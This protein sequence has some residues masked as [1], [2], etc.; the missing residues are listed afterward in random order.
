MTVIAA[1][2]GAAITAD[3]VIL[4]ANIS[5]VRDGLALSQGTASFVASLTTL[6]LAAAVLGA[7]VLGDLY[8]MKRMFVV[9]L[10]GTVAAGLMS[11]LAP[12]VAILMVARALTGVAFAFLLG[13]S[14]A[15]V[16]AV[17]PARR[18]MAAI[19]LFL[20]AGYVVT[21]PMAAIG[22]LLVSHYGWRACFLVAPAVAAVTLVITLRFV[23]ETARAPGRLDLPAVV[24]LGAALLGVIYGISR[25]ENG[26]APA[27]VAPI[28]LGLIAAAGFV[29]RELH[30]RDPALDLRIFSS[31]R[32]NA[33]VTAGLATNF[34]TGGTMILLGFYLIAVRRESPELLGW[35][36]IPAT[37]LQA[38]AAVVAGRAAARCGER[39]VLI[40]GLGLMLLGLLSL[41]LLTETSALTVLFVPVAIIAAAGAVVQTPQATI[42]MSSAPAD[43]GGAVSAV[44]AGIGMAGY[45]LGPTVFLLVGTSLFVRDETPR[46]AGTGVTVDE[47]REALRAARGSPTDT[48]TGGGHLL[49]PEQAREVVADGTRSLLDA[50]H[51]LGLVMA[52]VPAAAIAAAAVLLR[53]RR[54]TGSAESL[55][56]PGH[57]GS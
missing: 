22:G 10:L 36:L 20:A 15:L 27:A 18:R 21:A 8:G 56:S 14:L 19:A 49:D 25:L 42:M 1:G 41:T 44:K 34:L 43:L 40:A 9:G 6:T 50:I 31:A 37:L 38:I 33:A 45:S 48:S 51:S 53:R 24:L 17:F 28:L 2:F 57:P 30:T 52:V 35:L 3:P 4:A 16:N 5:K 55:R 12:N 11:A 47:A 32:F 46:L 29:F 7:G 13:L 39:V 23:P 26:L 54:P